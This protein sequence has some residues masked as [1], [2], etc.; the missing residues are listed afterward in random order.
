MTAAFAAQLSPILTFVIFNAFPNRFIYGNALFSEDKSIVNQLL[1]AAL[2]W[3]KLQ[4][5]CH[6]K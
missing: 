5:H 2:T 6:L 3:H 4:W 1:V